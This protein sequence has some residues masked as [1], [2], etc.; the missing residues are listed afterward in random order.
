LNLAGCFVAAIGADNPKKSEIEPALMAGARILVDDLE[1]CAI[2]GDLAHALNAGVISRASVHAD[3]ADL[4]S[5]RKTARENSY[6]LVIFDSSGSGVQ[7]VAAAWLAYRTADATGT[8]LR[9]DMTG[10]PKV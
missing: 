1:Q 10:D 5:G 9:F 7:D 2:G 6:E 8:G 4:A 3:L